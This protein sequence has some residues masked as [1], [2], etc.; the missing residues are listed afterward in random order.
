MVPTPPK[1][2]R[3]S[4][5]LHGLAPQVRLLPIAPS[6]T[7]FE[8]RP[9]Q[10]FAAQAAPM[11]TL[12]LVNSGE[13]VLR[14]GNHM[15]TALAP[16]MLVCHGAVAHSLQCEKASPID[17]VL[18]A[19]AWLVGPVAPLLL[20]EFG[21]PLVVPLGDADPALTHIISLVRGELLDP[22]CGHPA[23]LNSAGDIVFI[24]LLRH[25][26]SHP[27]ASHGL[28]QGLADP[29]IAKTLVAMHSTPHQPW[30]LESLAEHAGMSRTAFAVRFKDTLRCP[31]GKYLARLRL[32]IAQRTVQSGQGL[33]AAARA[34]GFGNVSALSRALSRTIPRTQPPNAVP[35]TPASETSSP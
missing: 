22:R 29:R 19:Q 7:A 28:F 13:V 23:L 20:E 31:P 27:G 6:E 16:A 8:L 12:H 21:E 3:L 17:A 9:T 4:A 1:L 18:T 2:D 24:A 25:L 26:V 10:H 5:L 35:P 15:L 11:L 34:A 14:A 32:Q 30:T 33:K